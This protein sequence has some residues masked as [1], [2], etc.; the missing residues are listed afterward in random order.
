VVIYKIKYPPNAVNEH[1][2]DNRSMQT[3]EEPR[4]TRARTYASGRSRNR[5]RN[6]PA[7]ILLFPPKLKKEKMSWRVSRPALHKVYSLFFAS[8]TAYECD[9]MQGQKTPG[10]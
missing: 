4:R 6:Q 10:Y 2:E 5:R 3:K 9:A 7:W 1:L 8:F